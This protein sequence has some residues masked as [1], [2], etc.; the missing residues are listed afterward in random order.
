MR[1]P[2]LTPYRADSESEARARELYQGLTPFLAWLE[3]NLQ[4]ST[5]PEAIE[6]GEQ[7]RTLLAS[8][9]AKYGP[10]Q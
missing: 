6:A 8:V 1:E 2:G 7:L 10:D 4:P 3:A 9:L 5:D